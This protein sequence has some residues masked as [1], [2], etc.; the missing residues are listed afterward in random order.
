[1]S[2]ASQNQLQAQSNTFS[3]A[4]SLIGAIGKWPG[5]GGTPGGGE[6]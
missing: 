4:S 6:I 2:Q 5:M 1:V 3:M